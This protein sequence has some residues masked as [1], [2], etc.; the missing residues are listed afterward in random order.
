MQVNINGKKIWMNFHHLYYFFTVVNEG[1]LANASKKLSIGQPS[2]S[3]QIKQF[4]QTLNTN[5]FDR[6]NKKLE[7]TET[8]KIA[9][10]M[11]AEIFK[12]GTSLYY[13]IS[14]DR[15]DASII[16]IGVTD[17]ISQKIVADIYRKSLKNQGKSVQI[18]VVGRS[19]VLSSLL[20]D[21]IQCAITNQ[22]PELKDEVKALKIHTSPIAIF[23]NHKYKELSNGFPESLKNTPFILPLSISKHRVELDNFISK[24][25][26]KINIVAETMDLSIQK[27]FVS[28][29]LGLMVAPVSAVEDLIERR[30]VFEIGRPP[31]TPEETFLLS[32]KDHRYSDVLSLISK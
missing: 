12:L 27:I 19:E 28:E 22:P 14:S 8:G 4:E 24:K 2:L 11:A 13:K 32:K 26:L 18:S 25:N 16:E 30:E 29:G 5:L 10:V 3:S 7:L 1:S 31:L 6:K 20:E 15:K 17:G 9:H 23:G 21:K